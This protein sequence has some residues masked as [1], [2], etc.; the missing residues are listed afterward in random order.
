[1]TIGARSA[2]LLETDLDVVG[3]E[4]SHAAS[5]F[6]LLGSLTESLIQSHHIRG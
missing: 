5:S 2:G 6:L 4:H 3:V 1:M